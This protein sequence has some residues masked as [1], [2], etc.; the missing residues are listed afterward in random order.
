MLVVKFMSLSLFE[1]VS[2]INIMMSLNC[3]LNFVTGK[4]CKL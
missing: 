2:L 4:V 3:F 1:L